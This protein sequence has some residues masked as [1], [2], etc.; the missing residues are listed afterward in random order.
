LD[1]LLKDLVRFATFDVHHEADAAS[2]VLER[3][4]VETLL[5]RETRPAGPIPFSTA[6]HRLPRAC[7]QLSGGRSIRHR[8]LRER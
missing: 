5:R 7:I 8:S 6:A 3:R 4:I 2:V 1:A